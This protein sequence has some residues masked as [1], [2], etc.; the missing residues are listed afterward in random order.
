MHNFASRMSRALLECKWFSFV[1]TSFIFTIG[2]VMV[3]S[4]GKCWWGSYKYWYSV[5]GIDSLFLHSCESQVVVWCSWKSIWVIQN[6]LEKLNI[7]A[8]TLARKCARC[9]DR[10]PLLC[11]R[12]LPPITHVWPYFFICQIF[13]LLKPWEKKKEKRH[14]FY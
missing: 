7:L 9:D 12:K 8:P 11:F 6:M 3:C 14:L 13:P 10:C 4:P 1:W 5:W 2:Q